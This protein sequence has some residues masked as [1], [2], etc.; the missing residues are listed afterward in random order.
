M[1]RPVISAAKSLVP[2]RSVHSLCDSFPTVN[3]QNRPDSIDHCRHCGYHAPDAIVNS[4][5][6][7]P[8]VPSVDLKLTLRRE[9]YAPASAG[10]PAF[11]TAPKAAV[12]EGMDLS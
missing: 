10:V 5:E 6:A 7:I 12:K 3:R 11:I 1:L 8:Y 9:N 2:Y 4:G